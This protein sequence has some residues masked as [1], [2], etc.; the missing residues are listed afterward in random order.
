MAFYQMGRYRRGLARFMAA[1]VQKGGA[2][3]Q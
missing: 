3:P 2:G 1:E